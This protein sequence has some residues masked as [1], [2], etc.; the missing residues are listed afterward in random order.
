MVQLIATMMK[1]LDL[2]W[3]R[4]GAGR[5]PCVRNPVLTARINRAATGRRS[6]WPAPVLREF[7]ETLPKLAEM[8]GVAAKTEISGRPS[9]FDQT[10]GVLS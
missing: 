5:S 7:A 6:T 2:G 8:L 4:R 10:P 9:E 1:G 3:T